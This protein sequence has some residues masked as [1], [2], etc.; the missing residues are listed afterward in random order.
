[1]W[2]TTERRARVRNAAHLLQN[3]KASYIVARLFLAGTLLFLKKQNIL[4]GYCLL[5]KK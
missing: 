4:C 5:F 3:N 2:L 1:M